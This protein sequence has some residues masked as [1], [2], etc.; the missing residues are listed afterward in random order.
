M[1]PVKVVGLPSAAA[2]GR[3][4]SIDAARAGCAAV[5]VND[6][7]ECTR[8]RCREGRLDLGFRSLVF[9]RVDSVTPCEHGVFGSGGDSTLAVQGATAEVEDTAP[10]GVTFIGA[11][12]RFDGVA[13]E[14]VHD[15]SGQS[16][17][18]TILHRA[19]IT[20]AAQVEDSIRN[21]CSASFFT[22]DGTMRT[23]DGVFGAIV[24]AVAM[25]Q[26]EGLRQNGDRQVGILAF[27]GGSDN[28]RAGA[29]TLEGSGGQYFND[30]RIRRGQGSRFSDIHFAQ[31]CVGRRLRQSPSSVSEW[32]LKGDGFQD[33]EFLFSDL[34][35]GKHLQR[36][37]RIIDAE[38]YS[39][40]KYRS[41]NW[42]TQ[43]SGHLR[44][45]RLKR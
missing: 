5:G 15:T 36:R 26:D 13:R 6:M 44:A 40:A 22:I 9:H 30:L 18:G 35:V 42:L 39:P 32:R 45:S 24:E 31:D 12:P 25:R 16:H 1:P 21:C 29:R 19:G 23:A 27:K 10:T 37:N 38:L 7:V 43:P 34:P 11:S 14:G 2:C 33:V 41:G 20:L 17:E 3:I 8:T 28:G 4:P